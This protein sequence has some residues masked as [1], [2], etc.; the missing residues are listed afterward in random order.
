MNE[1][2]IPNRYAKALI[3]VAQEKNQAKNIYGFL[4]TLV[5]SFVE[6]PELQ[7]SVANPYIEPQ[8]KVKLL[9]TAAGAGADNALFNDFLKL[10]IKNKRI[11]FIRD[12]ALSYL[13]QYRLENQIYLV[14]ITSAAT[15]ERQELDR[16]VSLVQKQL[17]TDATIQ[18]TESVDPSLIGGFSISIDNTKLDASIKN[19]LKQLRSN[20]ISQ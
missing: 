5:Q 14:N 1:G 11:S 4:Q 10:L 7:K 12:M 18:L 19:Q 9:Q 3:K 20:L 17:P 15:I 2:L 13:K 8:H 6:Q 16:L